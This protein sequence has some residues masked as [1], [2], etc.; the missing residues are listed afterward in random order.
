MSRS[1]LLGAAALLALPLMPVTTRAQ[2]EPP[3]P[4]R[5]AAADT[6]GITLARAVLAN[7]RGAGVL[8]PSGK[9]EVEIDASRRGALPRMTEGRLPAAVVTR[10]GPIIDEELAR[11]SG[12]VPVLIGFRLDR[13]DIGMV[14]QAD[15]PSLE[16]LPELANRDEMGRAVGEVIAGHPDRRALQR[17]R[18]QTQLRL[19]LDRSGEV[20]HVEA[21]PTGD[22]EVDRHLLSLAYAT[23]FRPAE[24][25]GRPVPAWT[26][27]PV[28]F[29]GK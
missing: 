14:R 16:R 7:I 3:E 15:D 28:G 22:P 27:A 21:V 17:A 29:Y 12:E 19:K 11:W 10:L 4:T 26:V 20:V 18:L 8:M 13:I 25:A 24:A 9:L 2:T 5:G 23:R 6:G 1:T